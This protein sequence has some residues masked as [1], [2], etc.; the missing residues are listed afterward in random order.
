MHPSGAMNCQALSGYV[1]PIPYARCLEASFQVIYRC[2][3]GIPA[4]QNIN[5]V[6]SFLVNVIT[7]KFFTHL[8]S[9]F[10]AIG[11]VIFSRKQ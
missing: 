11:K 2:Q 10:P 5:F 4:A 9:C 3:K 8:V 7:I 6:I 1:I